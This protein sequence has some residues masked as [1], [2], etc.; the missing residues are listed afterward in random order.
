MWRK[1][2][3]KRLNY[4]IIPFYA[5]LPNGREAIFVHIPKTAGTS[6]KRA[7]GFPR[8]GK[9]KGKYRK[10]HTIPEMQ[11]IIPAEVWERAFKFAIVRNPWDR[12]A[13]YY[14][15][16]KRKA[17]EKFG[18]EDFPD[19]DRW[20]SEVLENPDLYN[21]NYQP[22]AAW[23]YNEEGDL[24][25]DYV[26][27]FEDLDE[28]YQHICQALDVDVPPDLRHINSSQYTGSYRDF[29]TEESQALVSRICARDLEYFNYTF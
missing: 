11:Q 17:A 8:V 23:L 5:R 7:L 12:M 13:S 4:S 16:M 25:V 19:F 28:A 10:H 2:F 14:R 22:Q 6:L 15:F 3:P 18:R 24:L 21:T 9:A 20:L 26:G 1:L 29:Y 27:R